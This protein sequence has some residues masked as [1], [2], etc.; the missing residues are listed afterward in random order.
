MRN[1]VPPV[2]ARLEDYDI[3]LAATETQEARDRLS[4]RRAAVGELHD[5]YAAVG[6]RPHLIEQSDGWDDDEVAALLVLYDMTQKGRPLASLRGA[7][8][9]A[10]G[11]R[12]LLCGAGRPASLDH[13]LPKTRDPA[14]AVLHLNL[15]GACEPCN[16]RKATTRLADPGRQFVHPYFDR[17]PADLVYLRCDPVEDG[18]LAPRFRVAPPGG[19]DVEL[20]QR[21]AWQFGRLELDEFYVNEAM[22]YCNEQALNWL[23]VLDA[24]WEALADAL[25]RDLRS[26][27]RA[28]GSNT[29]KAALLRGLL[30][31]P[32][33]PPIAV[34]VLGTLGTEPTADVGAA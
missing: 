24:G 29:W 23:D 8:L 32:D 9:K 12:C 26:V 30:D 13:V 28:Y 17:L 14:L 31:A 25:R 21:V 6:G 15:I 19:M 3:G 11:P 1:V 4:A 18:K 22:H 10:A 33:F 5:T 34:R 16:R 7:V 2:R 20:G 27:V